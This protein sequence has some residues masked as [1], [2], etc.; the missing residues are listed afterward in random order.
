MTDVLPT[1]SVASLHESMESRSFVD[2]MEQVGSDVARLVA[3]FD[4]LGIRAVDPRQ[5]TAADGDAACRGSAVHP[6][7][8]Q[9]PRHRVASTCL[10]LS[11]R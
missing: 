4:D 5:D 8:V 10:V 2:A 11:Y 9:P 6:L 1:W 3:L 7:R